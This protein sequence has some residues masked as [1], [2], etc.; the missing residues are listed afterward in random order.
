MSGGVSQAWYD[1]IEKVQTELEKLPPTK[2]ALQLHLAHANFQAK[3]W[4]QS[5]VGVQ[6]IGLPSAIG[7]WE[8]TDDGQLQVVWSPLPSIPTHALNW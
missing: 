7:S 6:S 3:V 1:M 5:N 4:L 2:A 8:E